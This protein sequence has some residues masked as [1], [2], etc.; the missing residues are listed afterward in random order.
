MFKNINWKVFAIV[1]GVILTILVLLK[2]SCNPT[3]I[4]PSST[5]VN[6]KYVDSTRWHDS[7]R[8]IDSLVIRRVSIPVTKD[9][10]IIGSPIDNSSCPSWTLDRFLS[11]PDTGWYHLIMS[12]SCN[13][14]E[15]KTISIQ[16]SPF[17]YTEHIRDVYHSTS[18]TVV[19]KADSSVIQKI[20]IDNSKTFLGMTMGLQTDL[21]GSS[22]KNLA[23][24]ESLWSNKILPQGFTLSLQAQIYDGFNNFLIPGYEVSLGVS[25]DF[26]IIK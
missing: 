5:V 26:D 25:K 20:V 22:L 23:F 10:N 1:G 12:I 11:R 18:D 13:P 15:V 21:M 19:E 6:V 24:Q 7:I 14:P 16:A 3:P 8:V 4:P 9:T 2:F 17:L